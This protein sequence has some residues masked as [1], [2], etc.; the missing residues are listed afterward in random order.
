LL[1]IIVLPMILKDR[2]ASTPQEKVTITMPNESAPTVVNPA[3]FDSNVVPSEAEKQGEQA[4]ANTTPKDITKE[5][6]K[7]PK[8]VKIE[9]K[10]KAEVAEKPESAPKP[11]PSQET[12]AVKSEKQEKAEGSHKFSVQIGVFSDPANVKQ[13]QAKLSDLGYQSK[14]EKISTDKGEKIRLKT[15]AF[16]DRNEAAIALQNIK[17]AGLTGMVISQ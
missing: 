9:E 5:A 11:Q 4:P 10:P 16:A 6:P 17:D 8:E 3:D 15:Q 13:L 2:A 7:E 1:M 12:K 14:T